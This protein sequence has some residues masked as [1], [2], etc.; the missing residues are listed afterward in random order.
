MK[1]INLAIMSMIVVSACA[2]LAAETL[3]INDA[4][5]AAKENSQSYQLS[6]QQY[7]NYV[8]EENTVN[9]FIPSLSLSGSLS[10]G[11]GFVSGV[12]FSGLNYSV[13]ANASLSLGPTIYNSKDVKNANNQAQLLSLYSTEETLYSTVSTAYLNVL[14]Y[15]EA[16]KVSGKSV[17][18]AQNQYDSVLASYNAGQTSE[19]L[20]KQAE[21]LLLSAEYENEQ[22][23][24]SLASAERSFKVLTGVDISSYDLISLEELD[25]LDLPSSAEIF[26]GHKENSNSIQRARNSVTVAD[27]AL[28]TTK[29]SA[30]I[31]TVSIGASYSN[32]GSNIGSYNTTTN[33]NRFSDSLTV[34]ASVSVP[35]DGY[36]P[37][38]SSNVSVKSAENS[39]EYARAEL[40][41]AYETLSSSID[42][43]VASLALLKNQIA[44][45]EQQVGTLTYQAELSQQAYDNGLM[46][47][48]DL[49]D[50][51]DSLSSGE[52]SLLSAKVSY[53]SSVNTLATLIGTDG[54]GIYSIF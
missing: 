7:Q 8:N 24:N 37:G 13:G 51:Y 10:T 2:S 36:L 33:R 25:Y 23:N 34:S 27:L 30:Y 40:E 46:S 54:D 45:L 47:L 29:N 43:A 28:Q 17:T 52:Y 41:I 1:K 20:L 31:P 53:I 6:L 15:R 16:V 35:L 50:V 21:N 26:E 49:Q 18:S 39:A 12:S 3:T 44:M 5:G 42:E 48:S 22:N 38:S 14:L 9:P 11:A 4:F 32:S 19:L